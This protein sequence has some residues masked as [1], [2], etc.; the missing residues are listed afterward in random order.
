[1]NEKADRAAKRGAKGV[2][3]STVTVKIGLAD[4]YEEANQ[5]GVEAVGEGVPL[6]GHGQGVGR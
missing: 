6:N 4:V 2:D 5:A 1:M 3:S